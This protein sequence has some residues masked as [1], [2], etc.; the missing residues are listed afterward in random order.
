MAKSSIKSNFLFNAA[1][2]ILSM[3]VPLV[4]TP[5]VSRVLGVDG[6]GL[7][8]YTFAIAQYFLLFVMLGLN[9]YGNRAIARVRDDKETLSRTFSEI[10]GMQILGGSLVILVYGLYVAFFSEQPLLSLT[11]GLLVLSGL[12]DINWFFF[13]VEEFKLI[14]VRNFF[15]KVISL[16]LIFTFVKGPHALLF[17]SF[18]TVFGILL[19]QIALFPFLKK[20]ISFSLPKVKD[21]IPHIKPNLTLFL[22]VIA[23]SIY[24]II[25]KIILGFVTT[26]A[27]VGLYESAMKIISVP[28]MIVTALGTVMLPRMSNLIANDNGEH[29][30]LLSKS[31]IFAIFIS[32]AMAFGIMGISK[33]FVPLFYGPGFEKCADLYLILLPTCI[34]FALGNVVR[35]QVLIPRG[36]DRIYVTSGF[37]GAAV[38]VCINLVLIPIWGSIGAAI[39]TLFTET[40]VAAYQLMMGRRYIH[41]MKYAKVIAAIIISGISMFCALYFVEFTL[42]STLATLIVKILF[43]VV[44]YGVCLGGLV[45]AMRV[46]VKELR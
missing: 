15:I 24:T 36:M 46:K 31:F 33:L 45:V 16:V 1:Y 21:I 5:Y 37:M 2:Q 38:N 27:E 40:T 12:F 30:A 22:T 29:E 18:V 28:T 17:Y 41:L 42:V 32:S 34:A 4:T 14:V 3:F 9:N 39:G 25:N 44:V 11:M 13:G 43:G 20:Y 23:V 19:S 10:Y 7:F 8:S 6:I 35:T 26:P